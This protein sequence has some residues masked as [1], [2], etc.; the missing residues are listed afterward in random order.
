MDDPLLKVTF[1][2]KLGIEM[3]RVEV[4]DD[5]GKLAHILGRYKS[6]KRLPVPFLI[7]KLLWHDVLRYVVWQYPADIP[8]TSFP[9]EHLPARTVALS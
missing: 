3:D 2:S 9:K 6:F 1:F 7:G 8:R 4:A 5:R